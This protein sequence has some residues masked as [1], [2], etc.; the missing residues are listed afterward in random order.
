MTGKTLAAPRNELN[1][2]GHISDGIATTVERY[3]LGW[4][5]FWVIKEKMLRSLSR[6]QLA[7]RLNGADH[8]CEILRG[9]AHMPRMSTVPFGISQLWSASFRAIKSEKH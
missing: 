9:T 2:P 3:R 6:L 5:E 8:K 4:K 7:T 1:Q